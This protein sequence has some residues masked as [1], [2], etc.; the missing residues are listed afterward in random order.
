MSK[1]AGNDS[2]VPPVVISSA[3]GVTSTLYE[4][5]RKPKKAKTRDDIIEQ[6][7]DE[8]ITLEKQRNEQIDKLL[9]IYLNKNTSSTCSEQ[10]HH[11]DA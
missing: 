11:V 2:I 7:L 6:K 3:I 1:Q 10:S 4:N 9:Q 5:T 8:L